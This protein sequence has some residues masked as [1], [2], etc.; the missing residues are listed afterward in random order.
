MAEVLYPSPTDTGLTTYAQAIFYNANRQQPGTGR[1]QLQARVGW[2]TLN[3]DPAI[4]V[5]EWGAKPYVFGLKAPWNAFDG[6]ANRAVAR[7]K[8]N[9]Q[10]KLMPIRTSRFQRCQQ[11]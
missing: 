6:S 11:L 7:V 5:P 8:L 9:W 10:A 4:D 2:D 3:W 1:G